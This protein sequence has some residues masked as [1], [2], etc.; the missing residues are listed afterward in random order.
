MNILKVLKVTECKYEA[1][2]L[3]TYM[4]WCGTLSTSKRQYQHYL[5]NSAINRWF[6]KE[7][8]Q[9]EEEFLRTFFIHSKLDT[10]SIRMYYADVTFRIYQYYPK[11]LLNQ[12]ERKNKIPQG[13][14]NLN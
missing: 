5:A 12:Y 1:M 11:P 13:T 10:K 6:N 2:R 3:Q 4:S 9:L 8:N 7:Y 14:F